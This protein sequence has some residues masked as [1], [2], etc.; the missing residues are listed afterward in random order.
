MNGPKNRGRAPELL[1]LLEKW[2]A[3]GVDVTCDTYPYTAGSTFV[4][5]LLPMWAV[6]GGP[7]SILRRLADAEARKSI[8]TDIESKTMDWSRYALVGA[9]SNTNA[10]YEG[11]RFDEIAKAR[12]LSVA[13]WICALLEED[14]LRACYVSHG[15]H[16]GNVRDIMQWSRQMIGSDGLH[17]PGKTHPR[18]YGTFPRILGYYSRE[19]R[20]LGM[21]EAVRKMTSAPAQRLGL[22]GRGVLEKGAFAD[23]V[24]FNPQT[25]RDVATFDAPLCYPTGIEWVFVNGKA[26]K[27]NN[28]ATHTLG[29]RILRRA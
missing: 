15:A 11:R 13:E 28:E 3:S 26:A 29:G 6:E 18:L 17:L 16:E 24:L 12:G 14:N 5:S 21:E 7:E 27:A 22:K 25:V 1:D 23:I 19:E 2:V 10:P 9:E 8:V 4:Q 20:V